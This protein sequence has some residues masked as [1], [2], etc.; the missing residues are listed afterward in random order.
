MTIK[1]FAGFSERGCSDEGISELTE[2]PASAQRF[3]R[4]DFSEI[5]GGNAVF[6]DWGI[7]R[8]RCPE[9]RKTP[10]TKHQTLKG[11]AGAEMFKSRMRAWSRGARAGEHSRP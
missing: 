7:F 5:S 10:N 8:T 1:G 11:S 6:F 9:R 2:R 4:N 3:G